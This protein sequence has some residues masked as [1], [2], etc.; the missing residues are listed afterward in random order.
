MYVNGAKVAAHTTKRT[1]NLP[2]PH[3][4]FSLLSRNLIVVGLA[5][6][7]AIL[8]AASAPGSLE[9]AIK[10]GDLKT[11]RLLV[12]NRSEVNSTTPDGSTPL[13]F[14]VAANDPVAT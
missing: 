12:H 9:E 14:A 5:L 6:T 7:V 11:V 2:A 10:S 1:G 3:F 8:P 13:H 4:V